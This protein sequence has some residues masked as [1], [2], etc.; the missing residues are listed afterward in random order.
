MEI[1]DIVGTAVPFIG[2][3]HNNI[4]ALYCGGDEISR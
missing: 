1:D 2:T 4:Q 3:T